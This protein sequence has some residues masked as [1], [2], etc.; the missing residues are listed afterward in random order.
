MRLAHQK[1][2]LLKQF[3]SVHP[4]RCT[5]DVRIRVPLELAAVC[6]TALLSSFSL[7][8]CPVGG[9]APA[10]QSSAASTQMLTQDLICSYVC[11]LFLLIVLDT[12]FHSRLHSRF[13]PS[14]LKFCHL[15]MPH[16]TCIIATA[17]GCCALTVAI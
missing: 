12:L 5:R 9:S 13:K 1:N 7:T 10:P 2:K 17:T 11:P 6:P 15:V 8:L 3:V 4:S 14:G 16:S